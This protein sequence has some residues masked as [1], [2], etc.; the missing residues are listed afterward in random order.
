MDTAWE[1]TWNTSRGIKETVQETTV[2]ENSKDPG[3]SLDT[4]FKDL[5]KM[6]NNGLLFG[7]SHC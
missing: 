5:D 3:H 1:T 6:F 4:S 7:K 2:L